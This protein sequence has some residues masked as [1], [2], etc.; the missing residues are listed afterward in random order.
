MKKIVLLFSLFGLL[1][2]CADTK[3]CDVPTNGFITGTGQTVMMGS[4]ATIDVFKKIDKAWLD[5]DYETLKAHISDDGIYRHS[6]GNISNN[7][8]EFIAIIEKDYQ[9]RLENG[10]NWGWTT[11]FAF[12]V[13]PSASDDPEV[14]NTNG[15]W[16]CAR[17]TSETAVYDEWYQIIDGKLVDWT[18]SKRELVK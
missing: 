4:E 2:S 10:G 9:D 17:F 3:P 13:K 7:S 6:D 12:S 8:E 1:V 14:T 5:R 11:S 15:E 18:S 16:V